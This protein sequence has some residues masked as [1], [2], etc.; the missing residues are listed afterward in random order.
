M[1]LILAWWLKHWIKTLTIL[2]KLTMIT[3]TIIG[4]SNVVRAV[5]NKEISPATTGAAINLMRCGRVSNPAE[6]PSQCSNSAAAA[7]ATAINF[8]PAQHDMIG[9]LLSQGEIWKCKTNQSRDNMWIEACFDVSPCQYLVE[10]TNPQP[11]LIGGVE[12]D[13]L[14]F[15]CSFVGP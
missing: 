3:R 10:N 11:F 4:K 13:I 9:S 2:L 15:R 7:T 6:H 1:V 5:A 12:D 14:C 8:V